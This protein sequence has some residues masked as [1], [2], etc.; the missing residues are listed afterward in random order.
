MQTRYFYLLLLILLVSSTDGDF[1][2]ASYQSLSSEAK[3]SKLWSE[4]SANQTPFSFYNPLIL[5]TIFIESMNPTFDHTSDTLP[6]FRKKL[7]HT[8]GNIAQGE[9]IM[10][11]SNPYT[12]IFQGASNVLIRLSSAKKPDF[13]KT[14]AAG[15]DDNLTPGMSLKFLRD[16]L[17]SANLLAMYGVNGFPSWNFFFKD[18]SNHI[19][20]AN[21]IP[22]KL[23]S[24][25]F[26]QATKYITE[27]GM[28]DM[29]QFDEKGRE[30]AEDEANFPWKLIFRPTA[31]AKKLFP[32]NFES[33]YTD[34]L[35][36]IPIGTVI[37]DV[38]AVANPDAEPVKIGGL[39]S[40][41]QF[42]TSQWADENLFFQHK[43]MDEDLKV[44]PE[45]VAKTPAHEGLVD[46]LLDH[47]MH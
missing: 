33:E 22:L 36:R 16:G 25:K 9:L 32:D 45:W 34:Q 31:E 21:G 28:K 42:I 38:L 20:N 8:V 19:P 35:K 14:T 43:F 46:G 11:P 27:I 13:S 47:I 41:T 6:I 3:L 39:R 40:R 15:A 10:D 17:P 5:G 12:G 30:I 2:S 4:I 24:C 1:S 26:A 23:L 37:Y 29:A 7:I 44:H 18:F